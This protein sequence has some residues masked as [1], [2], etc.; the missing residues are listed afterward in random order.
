MNTDEKR[1]EMAA[2]L[3]EVKSQ[4]REI[5][6]SK[7]KFDVL[8]DELLSL[9]GQIDVEPMRIHVRECDVLDEAVAD[10]FYVANTKTC[11]IFH[12]YGGYTII[13]D[14][15][16]ASTLYLTLVELMSYINDP[17]AYFN[18]H[19][20][21]IVEAEREISDNPLTDAEKEEIIARARKSIET[22]F[23]VK[24]F[25]MKLPWWCF[26]DIST[27]Y[28]VAGI[29]YEAFERMLED[30]SKKLQEEDVDSNRIFRDAV[31]ASEA[32][33]ESMKE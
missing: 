25:M 33:S 8:I 29:A 15:R 23:E 21:D 9:K 19:V 17:E 5:S 24:E 31:E 32:I 2:R 16:N 26:G 28:E 27:T 7:K 30:A 4:L 12:T 3:E 18:A 22:D 6:G 20:D 14:N 13:A 1:N 11:A 10:T